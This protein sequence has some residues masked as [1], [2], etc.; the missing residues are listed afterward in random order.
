MK[1][2]TPNKAAPRGSTQQFQELFCQR[3]NCS[4]S[5]YEERAFRV[6]LY[7]HARWLA[8]VLRKLK[9]DLFAEDFKFIRYLGASTGLSKAGL[10]L[11]DFRHVNLGKR[12]FWRISLRI[13]LSSR[14]A[15]R[16]A[17]QLFAQEIVAGRESRFGSTPVAW[18]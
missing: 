12:S 11:L 1:T 8:P 7:W 15:S 13:R 17:Q 10:D 18:K 5:E 16:L 9:P 4:P 2:T 14:K 6:C 3:F